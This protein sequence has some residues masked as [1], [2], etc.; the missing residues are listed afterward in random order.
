LAAPDALGEVAAGGDR[1]A[2]LGS[3][4]ILLLLA[5]VAPSRATSEPHEASARSPSHGRVTSLRA[6][7]SGG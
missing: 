2:A 7:E 1:F 6:Y 4:S 3:V 5:A